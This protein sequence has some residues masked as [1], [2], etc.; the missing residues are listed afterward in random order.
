[1][2]VDLNASASLNAA[3]SDSF[4]P[5][6]S[7]FGVSSVISSVR[8]HSQSQ[9]VGRSRHTVRQSPSVSVKSVIAVGRRSR[10]HFVFLSFRFV[11][12]YF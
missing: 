12:E 3:S 1:M 8:L 9:S 4:T 10:V 6:S 2:K 5:L 11:R 7:R